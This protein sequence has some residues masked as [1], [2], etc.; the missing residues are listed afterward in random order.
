MGIPVLCWGSSHVISSSPLMH[1][2]KVC[3]ALY[4]GSDGGLSLMLNPIH[5]GCQR[6][7]SNYTGR[8]NSLTGLDS[9]K[10]FW[11]PESY[12]QKWWDSERL[13]LSCQVSLTFNFRLLP[14]IWNRT[15]VLII[16]YL[17]TVFCWFRHFQQNTRKWNQKDTQ[18]S[19][20]QCIFW[21]VT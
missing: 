14:I 10:S 4:N 17:T 13:L 11:T 8:K 2:W 19:F 12:L 3:H 21:E 20:T 9:P 6:K 1:L 7:R 16:C 15:K 5:W 18:D